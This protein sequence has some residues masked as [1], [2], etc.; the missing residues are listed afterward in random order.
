M[1]DIHKAESIILE[2]TFKLGLSF[3]KTLESIDLILGENIYSN[4]DIPPF[5]R[6]MMDGIAVK[7]ASLEKGI[8]EFNI[9]GIQK[10]GESLNFYEIK[11]NDCIEIMTG[12]L[13]PDNFDFIIKVE[14]LKIENNKAYIN[15]NIDL[16]NH[17]IHYKGS[18][19]KKGELLLEENTKIN[20]INLSNLINSD[21]DRIRIINLPKIAILS[22]GSELVLP[23]KTKNP[24][25]INIT[26]PFVIKNSLINF[27]INKDK[28]NFY[29]EEDN[30]EKVRERIEEIICTND[31]VILTGAVSMGKYDFIPQILNDLKVNKLFHKVIQKPGKPFWFGITENHKPIFALPGN[32]VSVM[33]CLR[34]YIIPFLSKLLN[35]EN[36]KQSVIL[37]DDYNIR[38]DLYNF[39]PVKIT[40]KEG[41]LFAKKININNSGDYFSISKS[42]GFVELE[43]N[44]E[45]KKGD[46]SVFYNWY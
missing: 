46:I 27:G 40:N 3:I 32:P 21:K 20:S 35:Q 34:R 9:K 36:I 7:K 14:D 45:Y 8:K 43:K 41:K 39:I 19:I 23:F 5:N 28:I 18:D 17:F 4:I 10:P 24:S 26:N 13:L 2:N 30:I 6:S 12:A 11:E 15:S 33:V 37:D 25:Q 44:K 1:I 31:I 38:N 22:T 42:N 16:N 29:H